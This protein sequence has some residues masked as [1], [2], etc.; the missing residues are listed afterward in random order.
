MEEVLE[1]AND[2]RILVKMLLREKYNTLL[3][4]LFR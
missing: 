3:R 2:L 4:Q 1:N